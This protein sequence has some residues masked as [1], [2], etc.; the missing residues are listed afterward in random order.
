M[1]NFIINKFYEFPNKM[2]ITGFQNELQICF[3]WNLSIYDAVHMLILMA[4]THLYVCVRL[5][6]YS[7]KSGLLRNRILREIKLNKNHIFMATLNL[8]RI[9]LEI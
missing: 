5:Y 1:S 2:I 7:S 8:Y 9:I 3:P 6:T 4:I